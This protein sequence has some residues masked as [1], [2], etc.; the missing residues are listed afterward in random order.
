MDSD[1]KSRNVFGLIA[2][3]PE[4]ARGGIRLRQFGQEIIEPLGG[5]KIH[6]SWA[7][8]G[9]VREPLSQAGRTHIQNRIPEVR[10]EVWRN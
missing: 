7:V 6:P 2:A 4:L 3:Q 9:G 1:P 10:N 8:P 5:R